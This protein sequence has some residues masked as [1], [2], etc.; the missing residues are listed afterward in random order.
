[1]TTQTHHSNDHTDPPLHL[2]QNS[3]DRTDPPL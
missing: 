1:M 2:V 3:N